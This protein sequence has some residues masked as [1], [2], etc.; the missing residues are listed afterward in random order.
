MAVYVYLFK[1]KLFKIIYNEII[2]KIQVLVTSTIFQ[3][4]NSHVWLVV[5]ISD[6][7]VSV[8]AA[9]FW[10]ISSVNRENSLLL[11]ALEALGIL[12][13][14][15]PVEFEMIL[16]KSNKLD[17]NRYEGWYTS[18]RLFSLRV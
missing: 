6:S 2:F 3:M 11:M 9:K 18:N 16:L 15:N 13:H 17:F 10:V 1:I 8:I 4:L 12:G 14:L 5:I 7:D